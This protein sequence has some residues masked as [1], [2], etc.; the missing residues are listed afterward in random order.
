MSA[1]TSDTM[2]LDLRI[3]K[4]APRGIFLTNFDINIGIILINFFLRFFLRQVLLSKESLSPEFRCVPNK[5]KNHFFCSCL[6]T[7][8]WRE[9]AWHGGRE[10]VKVRAGR[11]V[12]TNEIID[13]GPGP[14]LL[15]SG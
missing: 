7:G 3:K 14:I 11:N 13:A 9:I 1:Q 10:G 2:V 15:C 4:Q 12:L 6:L 8:R 5:F